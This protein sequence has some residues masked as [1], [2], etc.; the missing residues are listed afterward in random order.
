MWQGAPECA[1]TRLWHMAAI[2]LLFP[3]HWQWQGGQPPHR[4]EENRRH[5]VISPVPQPMSSTDSPCQL[6]KG[7]RRRSQS[8]S[9]NPACHTTRLTRDRSSAA[10][11]GGGGGRANTVQVRTEEDSS[12]SSPPLQCAAAAR[13]PAVAPSNAMHTL[14]RQYQGRCLPILLPAPA[15]CPCHA[16]V[17]QGP[18]GIA[19]PQVLPDLNRGA[20]HLKATALQGALLSTVT[21]ACAAC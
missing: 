18:Q 21:A 11:A 20:C 14:T 2:R 15:T 12:H 17:I 8:A 16:V 5:T 19:A 6:P 4:R 1:H 7:G 13:R 9:T 3:C 10:G